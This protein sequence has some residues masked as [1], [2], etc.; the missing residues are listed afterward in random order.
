MSNLEVGSI[1]GLLVDC[2]LGSCA[3]TSSASDA[4]SSV[5]RRRKR[6]GGDAVTTSN[7]LKS[8]GRREQEFSRIETSPVDPE[9]LRALTS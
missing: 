7:T 9:H 3:L 4:A 1:A 8:V 6:C 2:S 5:L